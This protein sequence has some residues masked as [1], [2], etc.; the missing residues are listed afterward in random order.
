MRAVLEDLTQVRLVTRDTSADGSET[1][2]ISHEALLSAWPRLHHWL[3]QDRAGQRTHR[4]L[5][6]AARAWRAQGRDPS[7]LFGG[8]RLAVAREWAASH[9]RD[10]N[11]GER[12]FLVV[13]C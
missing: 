10:L 13:L 3:G 8:T 6:D 2:E 12:A 11:P 7:R 1:V 4:E 9:D 5:T